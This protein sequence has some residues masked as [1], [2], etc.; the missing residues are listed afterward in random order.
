MTTPAQHRDPA[1]PVAH[2]RPAQGWLNDPN[3]LCRVDGVW[4]VFFQFN[5]HSARHERI[6][7]GHLSSPDLVDWTV[8]PTAL[9]PSTDGPDHAGCWSGVIG[10]D[11]ATPVAV[12]S[13]VEAHDNTSS[14]TLVRGSEDLRH[15]EARRHV[16]ASMPEDEAVTAVR[17]P[18][19]VSIAGRRWALQGAGLADGQ[20]AVLLYDAEDLWHWKY[21]GVWLRSDLAPDAL[22]AQIWE[23]P[24]LVH[25]PRSGC[26]VLVVA[27]WQKAEHGEVTLVDTKALI[28][29]I[30]AP[31]AEDPTG[32]PRPRIFGCSE[33]DFGD[34][35][36]A[37]QILAEPD[38]ALLIGW[39]R[40]QRPQATSDEA[41]W[42]GLLTWPRELS[43]AG[44]RLISAPAEECAG[45][46]TGETQHDDGRHPVEVPDACDIVIEA[47]QHNDAEQVTLHRV[48]RATD[49]SRHLEEVF[50]GWADRIV[51][52]HSI[53]ELY[54]RDG[55]PS[56]LRVE[57][58]HGQIW[59]VDTR[60]AGLRWWELRPWSPE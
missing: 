2:P 43:V 33:V 53:V 3:G 46:R 30:E 60:G 38:R 22:E 23:C 48:H 58:D 34:S 51:I 16:A 39:A 15:W 14:V 21:R 32:T 27:R 28:L 59:Q 45:W 35:F 57:P 24:Q 52:D 11:D 25:L 7:W 18:F 54:R 42:A 49:G 47:P 55:A 8:E 1:F 37:P 41:G 56:T 44:G 36:Y 12:Y 5:P 9:T 6:H 40:E 10:F 19:L 4:H 29:E 17:D 31:D 26:W 50:T 20:A 13:G